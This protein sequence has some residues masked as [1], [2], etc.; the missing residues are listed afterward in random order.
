MENCENFQKDY[1]TVYQWEY[2]DGACAGH[3]RTIQ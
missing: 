1:I 2:A 3:V